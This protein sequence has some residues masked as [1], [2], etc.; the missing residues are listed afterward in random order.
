[1]KATKAQI[2]DLAQT[3]FQNMPITVHHT[4]YTSKKGEVIERLGA[5]T[6]HGNLLG[7]IT[8]DSEAYVAERQQVTLKFA[9]AADGNVRAVWHSK[10]GQTT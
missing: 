2:A 6:E 8:P 1:M 10:G 5:F 4:T 7:L 9:L 3:R